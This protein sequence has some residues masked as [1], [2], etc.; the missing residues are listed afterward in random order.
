MNLFEVLNGRELVLTDEEGQVIITW[1]R[2]C[3]FQLWAVDEN[4]FFELEIRTSSC[5]FTN[6]EEAKKY[7]KEW[8]N[9]LIFGSE[10]KP[11]S[12]LTP[13]FY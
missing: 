13:F 3:T 11:E 7:A 5:M 10:S 6:F 8:Q 1:N 2:S 12:T 9:E 4:E